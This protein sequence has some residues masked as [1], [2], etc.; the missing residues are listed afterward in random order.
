VN[1]ASS[2][3]VGKDEK[4]FS[5]GSVARSDW[6]TC[7]MSPLLVG[8]A[9]FV[10]V[11]GGALVGFALRIPE[12]HRGSDSRE[13][14][15]AGTGLI[16]TMTALV[17]GL[18][19]ASAKEAYDDQRRNLMQVSADVA[20]LDRLLA[21]YGPEAAGVRARLRSLVEGSFSRLWRHGSEPLSAG[22]EA[23]YDELDRLPAVTDLQRSAKAAA[24][25]LG[26]SIART[27]WL[28]HTQSGSAIS[29]PLLVI[30][31][32]WLTILFVG[33]GVYA[34]SNATV[35]LAL[36]VCALSVAAAVFLILELD[37]P[38]EGLIR[39]SDAPLRDVASRLGQ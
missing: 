38:F 13:V 25:Q 26:M 22:A 20:V 2:V 19:V 37:S 27:R 32:F 6:K 33:F 18:L 12:R 35:R 17:L 8:A 39:I 29:T 36:F 14:L 9:V 15:N 24:E 1:R 30:V 28:M 4:A 3:A 21:G 16:A 10:C 34:Q 31:V 7:A 11:Y 5:D 23:L